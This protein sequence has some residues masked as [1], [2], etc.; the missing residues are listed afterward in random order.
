MKR[1]SFLFLLLLVL[2]FS[3]LILAENMPKISVPQVEWDFGKVPQG[4]IVSHKYWIKNSGTKVLHIIRVRPGCGC[5]QAPLEKLFVPPG[6]STKVELVFNSQHY[7]GKSKK[8]ATVIS[9]DSITGDIRIGFAVEV[10]PNFDSTYPIYV[11]PSSLTFK[12]NLTKQEMEIKN[13]S[14][15]KLKLEIVDFPDEFYKTFLTKTKLASGKSCKL[16]IENKKGL[17]MDNSF[18]SITLEAISDTIYRFTLPVRWVGWD[19][20]EE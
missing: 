17:P 14:E 8:G 11:H 1:F 12:S 18:K 2:P 13:I 20:K 5:T 10:L 7:P 16:K 9:T 4:G 19:K 6:D 3:T 15:K